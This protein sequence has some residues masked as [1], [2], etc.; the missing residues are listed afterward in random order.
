MRQVVWALGKHFSFFPSYYLILTNIL[1]LL[2]VLYYKYPTGRDRKPAP[3]IVVTH[4]STR[5]NGVGKG[6]REGNDR[7]WA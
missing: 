2:Q 3:H 5:T 6:A 1:L 4:V 7:Q